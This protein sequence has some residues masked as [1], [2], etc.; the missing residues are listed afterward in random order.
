MFWFFKDDLDI[1][2]V[3]KS[4][5]L[6]LETY[7]ITTEDGYIIQVYSIQGG[8]KRSLGIDLEEKCLSNSKYFWWSLSRYI[9]TSCQEVGAI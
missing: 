1:K 2:D 4:L 7:E 9:F 3:A 5:E 6:P 8:P